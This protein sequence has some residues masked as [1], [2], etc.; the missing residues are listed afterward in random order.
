M[1]EE[2]QPS[3]RGVARLPDGR[4]LVGSYVGTFVQ[5][6]DSPDA[7]LRRWRSLNESGVM[8]SNLTLP[9]GR[10]LA[11][12]E[13]GG[14]QLISDQGIRQ[15]PWHFLHS[16]KAVIAYCVLRTRAGQLWGGGPDGL[17]SIDLA[18]MQVSRYHELDSAR[19]P[20]HQCEVNALAEGNPGELWLGTNRGLYWLCPATGE[21]RHYGP[22]EPGPRRL[23]S[24]NVNCLLL[25]HPDS[26]WVGTMDQ[27][28]LLHPRRGLQ[29]QLIAG[30]GLPS[31]S[32]SFLSRP[33]PGGAGRC[34]VGGH[35]R[36]AGALRPAHAAQHRVLGR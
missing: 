17:Y 25:T 13:T 14:F 34:L 2:M 18:R 11:A 35:L 9:D 5:A 16:E 19:W 36:R 6:A 27:G 31:A 3:T 26:L 21:L 20:L 10:L 12:N 23:P 4:L 30:Q 8:A 33:V 15:V 29:Q 32:V 7:P 24:A 1:T 22:Q 28:L